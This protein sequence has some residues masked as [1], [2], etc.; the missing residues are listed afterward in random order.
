MQQDRRLGSFLIS[1]VEGN[2]FSVLDNIK[3]SVRKMTELVISFY[4]D[5]S[6]GYYCSKPQDIEKLSKQFDWL[7]SKTRI[8]QSG[9]V[10]GKGY[11]R[12]QRFTALFW[13]CPSFERSREIE[14]I[15]DNTWA[16]LSYDDSYFP[17]N[18]SLTHFEK[19][20]YKCYYLYDYYR[21]STRHLRSD[22]EKRAR[23]LIYKMKYGWTSHDAVKRLA[24][25]MNLQFPENMRT[26][27]HLIIP[28]H[29][30]D[31]VESYWRYAEFCK[32]L[33]WYTGI[34]NG[35]DV[36]KMIGHKLQSGTKTKINIDH[37]EI[38]RDKLMGKYIYLIDDVYTTGTSFSTMVKELGLTKGLVVGIFLGKTSLE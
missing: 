37:L 36:I 12:T 28:I 7:L 20:G 15:L 3:E 5:G 4:D 32:L 18:V 35:Y 1:A 27:N 30:S 9:I 6:F 25:A 24:F 21:K 29:A 17:D 31:P 2:A 13:Q 34:P 8:D 11:Y 26:K 10:T 22:H 23:N 19:D 14:H 16:P 33:S 38:D